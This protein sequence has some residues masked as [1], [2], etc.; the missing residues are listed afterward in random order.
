MINTQYA[1]VSIFLV[2]ILL[3]L[4]VSRNPI[5]SELK[6]KRPIQ[7]L[8]P[9]IRLN[10]GLFSL[11]GL[12]AHLRTLLP[13]DFSQLEKPLGKSVRDKEW[14]RLLVRSYEEVS[15]RDVTFCK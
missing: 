3:M 2:A 15:T 5:P 9:S 4:H 7:L 12:V 13:N 11:N 10:R 8:Q 6:R 14:T 1:C